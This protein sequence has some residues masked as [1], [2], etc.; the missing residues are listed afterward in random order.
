MKI[1]KIFVNFSHR[2]QQWNLVSKFTDN[3]ISV[4]MIS[5]IFHVN[6]RYRKVIFSLG[7]CLKIRKF[8]NSSHEATNNDYSYVGQSCDVFEVD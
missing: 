8:L 7:L 2:V 1:S 4:D 3:R 5:V 6:I